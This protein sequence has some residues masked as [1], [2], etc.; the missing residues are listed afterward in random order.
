MSFPDYLKPVLAKSH[1]HK[2]L[3]SIKSEIRRLLPVD[4]NPEKKGNTEKMDAANDGKVMMRRTVPNFVLR[5]PELNR[6]ESERQ[7]VAK[8]IQK[9]FHGGENIKQQ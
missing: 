6:D 2:E 5:C 9:N 3:E 4:L 8:N 1:K 7:N